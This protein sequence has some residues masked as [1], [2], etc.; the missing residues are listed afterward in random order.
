MKIVFLDID[1]VLNHEIYAI[2]RLDEGY[3]TP[4]HNID[5]ESVKV[6]NFLVEQTDAKVVISSSWR[7]GHTVDELATKLYKSGF[8]GQ[9]I[10]FTPKL[11]FKT[12]GVEYNYSVPRGCE[13]KAWLE[14]N[15][16]ILGEKISKVKYVILDDDSDMLYWQRENYFRVDP[17]CGLT[18]N[19]VH[20]AIQFLNK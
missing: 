8:K 9:V 17:Y 18:Y 11:Y 4:V 15:K 14:L 12:D 5:P 3:K 13:I 19:V 1:G 7:R 10:D 20:R 16:D 6:L 2:K